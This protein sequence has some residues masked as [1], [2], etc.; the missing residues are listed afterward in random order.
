MIA[1]NIWRS[2]S[3]APGTAHS[4]IASSRQN[5]SAQYSP[6]GRKVAFVSDRSGSW[7][8]WIA[9]GDGSNPAPVTGF[10]NSMVGS[11]QWSPDGRWLAFDARPEGHSVVFLMRADGGS[12][13]P[14]EKNLFEDKRPTWSRDGKRI[15]FSSN[16]AGSP[17][18]WSAP[19]DGGPARVVGECEGYDAQESFDRSTLYFLNADAYLLQMPVAGGAARPVPGLETRVPSRLWTVTRNGIYLADQEGDRREILFYSFA[20]RRAV[21]AIRTARD[22]LFGTPNISLS[23]DERWLI[24]AQSDDMRSD[25]MQARGIF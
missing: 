7:Q 8:I 21:P 14:L 5:H 13:H 18:I 9:G 11:P 15:Y 25:L 2:A 4:F 20:S 22:L 6:D 23:P 12:A 3:S 10:R 17:Q 24:Y 16:R 1:S 19:A